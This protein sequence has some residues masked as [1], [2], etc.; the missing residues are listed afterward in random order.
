L[1]V[2]GYGWRWGMCRFNLPEGVRLDLNLAF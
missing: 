1:G 2:L